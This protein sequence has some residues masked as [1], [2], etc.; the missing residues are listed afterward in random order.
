MLPAD[1]PRCPRPGCERLIHDNA[2]I[3]S[4]CTSRLSSALHLC[5]R[6]AGDAATTIARLAQHA[7]AG[8]GQPLPFAWDAADAA[9]AVANTL[10]TWARH[11][12]Q[13]SGRALPMVQTR[14]WCDHASCRPARAGAIGPA[15]RGEPAEHPL[16]VVA[17]WLA[18]QLDWLRHRPEADQA[19]DELSDACHL[20]ERTVDRPPVLWYAG[21][22]GHNGCVGELYAGT[23]AQLVR[24]RECGAEH[25][26][27]GRREWLLGLAEDRL[28]NATWLA[29]TLT[30]LGH[31]V[32]AATIRKWAQRHR[33]LAHG[34]DE[35][36]WATYRFG[37]VYDL[38]LEAKAREVTRQ[39]GQA[40]KDAAAELISVA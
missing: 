7:V 1:L 6:L 35:R 23:G 5:A 15:C 12:S 3:C 11:V 17:S 13:E 2:Y 25:D 18:S 36:G 24:C 8:Q 37:D 28:A 10:T 22:C 39:A 16:A 14:T 30:V 32:S 31:P 19:F 9:W 4:L 26:A 21:P 40:R 34:T 29:G 20:L 27:D 38:V 33:L